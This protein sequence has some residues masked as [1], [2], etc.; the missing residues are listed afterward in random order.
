MQDDSVKVIPGVE[1]AKDNQIPCLQVQKEEWGGDQDLSF[2]DNE[3]T[4]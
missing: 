1:F 4:L 3:A 2:T